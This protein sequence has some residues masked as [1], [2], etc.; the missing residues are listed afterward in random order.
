MLGTRQCVRRRRGLTAAVFEVGGI[1]DWE[2]APRF[3]RSVALA[4]RL[5]RDQ[6]VLEAYRRLVTHA[7]SHAGRLLHTA[8]PDGNHCYALALQR[9]AERSGEWLRPPEEW[10]P[11]PRE[12]RLQFGRLARYLLARGPVPACMET[13][14][15]MAG[16]ESVWSWFHYVGT[17]RSIHCAPG[18]PMVMT[19]RMATLVAQ[20][21]PGYDLVRALRWSQ[22]V[23]LQLPP[24]L[25]QALLHSRVAWQLY[26]PRDEEWWF[27][28]YHW[29]SA[30]PG[31]GLED[32]RPLVDYLH[33]RRFGDPDRNQPP[34]PEFSLKHRSPQALRRLVEAWQ[35]ALAGPLTEVRRGFRRSGFLGGRWETGQGP[36][37]KIWAIEKLLDTHALWEEGTALNHCVASLSVPVE[38]GHC[39]I[40][41]MTVSRRGVRRRATTIGVHLPTGTITQCRGRSNRAPKLE[42]RRILERWAEENGL[43]ID[44]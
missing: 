21:P 37:P 2:L 14:F 42:E 41:S 36:D 8:C 25:V 34:D 17:G 16:P 26:E 18:M 29:L 24:P 10:H 27:A 31:V 32:V 33:A 22:L 1:G 6:A 7:E 11:R 38:S 30:H 23:G 40:W 39:S 9:L 15:F 28:F 44:I 19:R 35:Q 20:A 5:C 3:V 12:P 4:C 13:A 43:A